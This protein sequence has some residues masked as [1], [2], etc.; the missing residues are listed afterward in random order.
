[1]T[2]SP[3]FTPLLGSIDEACRGLLKRRLLDDV[4]ATADEQTRW[5][6]PHLGSLKPGTAR[7]LEFLAHNLKKTLVEN[8]GLSPVGTLRS[9][10]LY[11]STMP[12]EL[13]GVFAA[14]RK[15]FGGDGIKDLFEAVQN[16]NSFR[17]T[18]IAHQGKELTD[19][20]LA[21]DQLRV[22]VRTLRMLGEA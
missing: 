5:F 18:Y 4:P 16:V 1:M 14:V 20:Q 8:A 6:K 19:A 21:E 12:H 7:D 2:Y 13:P 10:F 22:W 9:A 17:N 15:R 3:I 11:A